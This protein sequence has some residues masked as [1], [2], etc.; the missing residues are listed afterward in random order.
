MQRGTIAWLVVVIAIAILCIYMI[1]PNPGLFGRPIEVRLGLDIQGGVRVLM[2]AD[3]PDVAPEQMDEVRRIIDRRVN[4]IGVAEPIVQ[5][6]GSNRI[7]VELP[8]IQN[9]DAAI[10]LIRQ[11]ALLEF[12]DFSAV[13]GCTAPMPPAGSYVL[14]NRQLALRQGSPEASPTPPAAPTAEATA[15]A[16]AETSPTVEATAQATA[17]A[18]PTAEV[19]PQATA[20]AS[21][22]VELTA[23]A[24]LTAEA[25]AQ[26]T[27]EAAPTAEAT[28]EPT[29]EPTPA[30]GATPEP[31]PEASPLGSKANPFLNPCTNLPFNTVM[32]G[33]GLRDAQARLGGRT[34]TEYVVGFELNTGHPE[35][36]AFAAHTGAN[37]GQPLAI[38]LDGEVLSAP[39]IQAR[40][41]DGG[42]ITGNFTREEAVTL[43]VQLRSGALPVSLSIESREQV[44]ATL[45]AES[46]AQAVRAGVLG[47]LTIFIFL[48]VYYRVGGVAA[49]LALILFGMINF[50]LYK[51]IPVT[52]TLSAITGFLIS[53][54]SAID[55]NILI[56]ERVK[57]ELRN[58]RKLNKAVE[59]GFS[60]AWATI[61]DSNI[62]TIMI[63]LILYFFGGQFGASAVRGFA[64]TLIIGLVINLF[65]A[66]VV[67]R[68]L[69]NVILA[70]GGERLARTKLFGQ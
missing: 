45:G 39:I 54:G 24:T 4:A 57:E 56:F 27:A 64:I 70:I 44:G 62:S 6:A 18:T 36:Q 28:L 3:Q 10:D 58:G 60:R 7:I 12:V 32:T 46:V 40:L 16:T 31:T 59:L 21:P 35:A 14:T 42:E 66:V 33:A 30:A 52:L 49:A 61:R 47:I 51:Y 11:T 68:V 22:T 9:P 15:Q 37:I 69:L 55:G 50:A 8:G 17:E 25:T 2:R 5:T 48:I 26:A 34:G 1:L 41:D 38:V 29:A 20:E 65:T 13:A 53:I 23:Q 19:T 67:T 63:A 43:A